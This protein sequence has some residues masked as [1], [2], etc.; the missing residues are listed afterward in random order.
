M[1]LDCKPVIVRVRIDKSRRNGKSIEINDFPSIF[2]LDIFLDL[3]DFVVLYQDVPM[4]GSRAGS[5]IDQT[6]LKQLHMSQFQV[7]S[8]L[9]P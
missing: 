7:I 6:I 9:G 8:T 1:L 2:S 3:Y 5:I 4:K